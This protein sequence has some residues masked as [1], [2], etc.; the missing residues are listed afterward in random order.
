MKTVDERIQQLRNEVAAHAERVAEMV[1][2]LEN[3]RDEIEA[4]G[5]TP[6]QCCGT[7]D[8]DNPNREQV[9]DIIKAF[10]GRWHKS[11]NS[12]MEGKLNYERETAPGELPLRI[13]SGDLPPTCRLES[14]DV[15]VPAH[16]EKRMKIVCKDAE[17][18]TE[19]TPAT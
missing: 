11:I 4:I 14:E 17:P 3:H 19:P 1:N 16:T 7:I 2:W 12:S 8:F 5:I 6:S 15:H 18:A 13:W 10:P 9:L